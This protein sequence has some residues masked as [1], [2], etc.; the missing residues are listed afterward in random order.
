[1]CSCFV[2]AFCCCCWLLIFFSHFLRDIMYKH[3]VCTIWTM[4]H[5]YT[6]SGRCHRY[7]GTHTRATC[8]NAYECSRQS[9]RKRER[10]YTVH[11]I[12]LVLELDFVSVFHQSNRGYNGNTARAHSH[13]YHDNRPTEPKNKENIY[14]YTYVYI[15]WRRSKMNK[16]VFF[17]R[18]R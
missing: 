18:S 11:N 14:I 12:V 1:M 16:T 4:A 15:L 10:T 7:M 2:R 9:K 5:A 8:M 3:F 6:C 13:T 17:F